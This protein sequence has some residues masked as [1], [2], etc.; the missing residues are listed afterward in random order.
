MLYEVITSKPQESFVSPVTYSQ[1]FEIYPNPAMDRINISAQDDSCSVQIF[2]ASGKVIISA[3]VMSDIDVS[4][5]TS[6]MYY[7]KLVSETT[8]YKTQKLLIVR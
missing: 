8:V 6:G 4:T 3:N 2:D 7:V 5:L 1:D